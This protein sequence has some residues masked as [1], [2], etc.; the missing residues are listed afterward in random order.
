MFNELALFKNNTDFTYMVSK[1]QLVYMT[2]QKCR[3]MTERNVGSTILFFWYNRISKMIG[4]YQNE[5]GHQ[6]DYE[7]V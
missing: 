2:E 6:R 5:K 1:Y 4:G 7:D 3:N